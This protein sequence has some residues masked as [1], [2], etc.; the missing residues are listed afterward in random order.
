[1]DVI[2]IGLIT[3]NQV[4]SMKD[5]FQKCTQNAKKSRLLETKEE[6][7]KQKN[8]EIQYN[9]KELLIFLMIKYLSPCTIL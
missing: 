7:Y 2:P 6:K 4:N 3:E 5:T 9:Y 8:L 1:M